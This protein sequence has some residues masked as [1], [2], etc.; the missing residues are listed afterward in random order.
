M[1]S[2][3][4]TGATHGSSDGPEDEFPDRLPTGER[5]YQEGDN[6]FIY[7]VAKVMTS[8]EIIIVRAKYASFNF[9]GMYICEIPLE[10]KGFTASAHSVAA[11]APQLKENDVCTL[12]FKRLHG[13][14][15]PFEMTL[16][17]GDQTKGG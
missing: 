11:A 8:G 6:D 1:S 12:V 5:M 3:S 4:S 10:N 9:P 15:G 2:P 13:M 16:M 14:K 7:R 17:R